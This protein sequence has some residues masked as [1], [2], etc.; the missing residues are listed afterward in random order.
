VTL[1]Y[2]V[3][4]QG[5][6]YELPNGHLPAD[7][8]GDLATEKNVLSIWLPEDD[9]TLRRII[10]AYAAQRDNLQHLDFAPIDLQTLL[11]KGFII[12]QTDGDTADNEVNRL[13]H[14]DIVDL[15]GKRLLQLADLIHVT[16]KKLEEANK[17]P[18]IA[19]KAVKK[20]LEES[21]LAKNLDESMMRLS[22]DKFMKK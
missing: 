1:V 3:I 17:S 7:V 8:L 18:R 10:A 12:K 5:R 2:R 9:E 19:I 22:P 15:S 11:D 21:Y 20:Y 14:R 16:L 13:Y 6:W 4:R